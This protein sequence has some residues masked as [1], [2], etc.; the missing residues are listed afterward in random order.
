MKEI[1]PELKAGI[2]IFVAIVVLFIFT[3]MIGRF[4]FFKK[5]YEIKVAFNFVEGLEVGSPVRLS[6]V[7]VGSVTDIQ[8]D[9]EDNLVKLR[10]WI[11]ENTKIRDDSKFYLNTLGFMGEKYIEIDP[12][13]SPAFLKN[14]AFV[15]GEDTR[16]LEEI[17][18][19]G[20]EIASEAGKI[21]KSVR[22]LTDRL[23]FEQLELAIDDF[24]KIM[25]ELNLSGTKILENLN[26]TTG[27]LSEIT[28][29]QKEDV[30]I[31]ISKLKDVSIK[32]DRILTTLNT[33]LERV[34]RGEG[35]LGALVSNKEVAQDI[36][37][38]IANL[39]VF[40]RDIKENPSWLIMGKPKKK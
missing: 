14:G 5:G 40:S 20:T 17:I 9:P 2:L 31:A 27:D 19:R 15:M 1:E 23:S 21:V 33:I 13:V 38:I 34:E 32:L 39:K 12:G 24:R 7:K 25:K 18:R 3:F 26:K 11:Q 30:Q 10:L 35:T 6:G 8:I 37:E 4:H 16:R 22:G 28:S 29:S 36:K